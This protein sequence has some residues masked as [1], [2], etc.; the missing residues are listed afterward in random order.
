MICTQTDLCRCVSIAILKQFILLYVI[1]IIVDLLSA[2]TSLL[3]KAPAY[4]LLCSWTKFQP[5][6]PENIQQKITIGRV[7]SDQLIN[8]ASSEASIQTLN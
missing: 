1:I 2:I 5:S 7:D 8:S 6:L 3:T 4:L